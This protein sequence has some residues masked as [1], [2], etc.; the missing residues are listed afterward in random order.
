MF[1]SHLEKKKK[2]AKNNSE[3]TK[4]H[5]QRRHLSTTLETKR[6]LIFPCHLPFHFLTSNFFDAF[7]LIFAL[8]FFPWFSRSSIDDWTTLRY[9][10]PLIMMSVPYVVFHLVNSLS[11]S[12]SILGNP[13]L[14]I[15][16]ILERFIVNLEMLPDVYFL[17]L[18]SGMRSN[19]QKK[20][21]ERSMISLNTTESRMC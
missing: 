12:S 18:S 15:L 17:P 14:Y 21:E 10:S 20:E 11:N 6:C 16:S 19:N 2:K 4:K 9:M 8:L 5:T 3:Y 1:C 7:C 13:L